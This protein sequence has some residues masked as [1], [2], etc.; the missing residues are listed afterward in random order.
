MCRIAMVLVAVHREGFT[1]ARDTS[2][3]SR[4]PVG[5]GGDEVSSGGCSLTVRNRVVNKEKEKEKEH[6]KGF[7]T[8]H[9]DVSRALPATS[10]APVVCKLLRRW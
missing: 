8:H 4:A 10:A 9:V 3:V 5:V 2:N 1:W 6:T 7:E